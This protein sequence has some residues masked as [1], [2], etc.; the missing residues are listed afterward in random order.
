MPK[1]VCFAPA[2]YAG[3]LAAIFVLPTNYIV[4]AEDCIAKPNQQPAEG[5]HW[6]Y[7]S[8]RT[9]NQKCWYLKEAGTTTPQAAAPETPPPAGTAV[10]RSGQPGAPPLRKAE[11][12]ALFQEFLRWH[13]RQGN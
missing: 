1:R 7:R 8:D 4:R 13:K 5:Q 10:A 2:L 9:T 6:Y 11:R 3:A 12:E